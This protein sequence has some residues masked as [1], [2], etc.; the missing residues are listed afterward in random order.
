MNILVVGGGGR[1]HAI[2]WKLSQSPKVEKIYCAPGNAGIARLAQCVPIKA[3]DIEG[4]C[5]FAEKQK[6]DL[7]VIAPDDPL[8]LGMADEMEKRGIRAFGPSKAAAAIEGSK[9]FSKNL[10][11]KYNIPTAAYEVFENS[12]D[13][14]E[15]LKN[16]AYPAVIKAEGLAL[17][18]GVIIAMSFEEAKEA[19]IEIME[20]KKFGAAGSRV[21]VEEFLTGREISVLAFCDGKTV[22]PMCSAQDHKRALDNDEGLNTGGMGA[23]SPSPIYD[24]ALA[25]ECMKNIFLP[26]VTAMNS[27]GCPFSGVLYFG[28]M[29]TSDGV[30]VIEYNARFGDPEA[31]AVLPRLKTDLLDIFMAVCEKRLDEIEIEWSEDASAC[32]IMASGGYPSKYAVGYPILG[33]DDCGEMVFHSGTAEKDGEIVTAGGRV[34]GVSALG[35]TL[36]EAVGNAYKAVSRISFKD[37]HYRHDIGARKGI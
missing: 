34:L 25:E 8:V 20:E 4:M 37:M 36:E 12:A 33:L 18:K 1:E 28:L 10:M 21:V 30:K 14:I 24:E 15:Y 9:V 32:I 6:I 27:E 35:K 29:S 19:V 7:A 16:S 31:Q 13:A 26:T 22:K 3:T 17:G 11:K 2:V 23:Y 5:S